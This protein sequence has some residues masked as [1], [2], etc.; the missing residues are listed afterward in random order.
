MRIADLFKRIRDAHL[1]MVEALGSSLSP[2][3]LLD[4]VMKMLKNVLGLKG[5]GIVVTNGGG[6]K[7][8]SFVGVKKRTI[9]KEKFHSEGRLFDY[10]IG[11]DMKA[12]L[13]LTRKTLSKQEVRLVNEVVLRLGPALRKAIEGERQRR[14]L[15]SLEREVRT[16]F[17]RA[18]IVGKSEPM[19][20]LFVLLEKIIPTN[21]P[22][23]IVGETGTG[24]ELIAKALHYEGP[25]S[26]EP[27]VPVNCAALPESLLESE[28][29]GYERGA[30]TGATDAKPGLFEVANKGTLFLDEIGS[31]P[32]QLQA[33]LLRVLETKEVWRLGATRPRRVDVRIIAASNQ[34]LTELV[35]ANQF[36][37]DLYYRLNIVTIN[38][39]PLRERKEDIPL[40]VEHFLAQFSKEFGDPEPKSI[41]PQAIKVLLSYDYPGNVR[42]L[43]NIVL[44]AY[45]VSGKRIEAGN[46]EFPSPGIAIQSGGI[47][48]LKE[49]ERQAIITALSRTEGNVKAAAKILG[50]SR[51]TL[52]RK[53][54]RL[55]IE[56]P[57][58]SR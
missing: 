14:R 29:F 28:L 1:A 36:R 42:E 25:R 43:R 21:L 53:C 15:S 23:L 50:I 44:R 26:S 9:E 3:G 34:S 39:P 6:L 22:V 35:V 17:G 49:L 31:L 46:I 57:Y 52:Y 12:V 5:C 19:R 20:R 56:I 27:F 24:K 41:S 4:L 2:E 47:L 54:R 33:K 58:R 18:N 13:Y 11:R 8:E 55:N 38:L 30:F 48:P 37:A 32:L 51:A 16:R 10:Q 40:L 45:A 7:C